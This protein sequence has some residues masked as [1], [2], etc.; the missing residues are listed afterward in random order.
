MGF[1]IN[2]H[3]HITLK[4]FGAT[5]PPYTKKNLDRMNR[6]KKHIQNTTNTHTG[7]STWICLWPRQKW[8]VVVDEEGSP[9]RLV[10]SFATSIQEKKIHLKW[11]WAVVIVLYICVCVC[12]YGMEWFYYVVTQCMELSGGGR[13]KGGCYRQYYY[14]GEWMYGIISTH[15]KNRFR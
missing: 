12:V 14:I 7:N 11:L 1:T 3:T 15:K 2:T 6:R 9:S 5:T 4:Q 13:S 10:T 8:D